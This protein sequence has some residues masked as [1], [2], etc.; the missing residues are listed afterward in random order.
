MTRKLPAGLGLWAGTSLWGALTA[1]ALLGAPP[2][3]LNRPCPGREVTENAPAARAGHAQGLESV[4]RRFT[5]GPL[6]LRRAARAEEVV[7][8]RQALDR[9]GVP[10]W[11]AAGHRGRGLKV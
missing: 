8:A 1:W 11:H 5:A 9:L 2:A 3:G 4:S 10:A 6:R 7:S